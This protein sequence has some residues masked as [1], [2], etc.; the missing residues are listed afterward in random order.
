M[1]KRRLTLVFRG[2]QA[3]SLEPLDKE[4]EEMLDAM[5]KNVAV[6]KSKVWCG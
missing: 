3:V 6:S 4:D 2:D 5:L 1:K